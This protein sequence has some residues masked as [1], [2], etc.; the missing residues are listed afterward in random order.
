M[1][2]IDSVAGDVGARLILAAD[3]VQYEQLLSLRQSVARGNGRI[4]LITIGTARQPILFEF[5]QYAS[6]LL[7]SLKCS[8]SS[9]DGIRR[10]HMST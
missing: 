4:R 1:G 2:L 5:R 3:E 10:C 7:K 8:E 6:R 9:A